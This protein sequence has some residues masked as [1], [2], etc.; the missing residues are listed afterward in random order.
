MTARHPIAKRILLLVLAVT[1]TILIG[2]QARAGEFF[3]KDGAAIR[4][5][6]PV[7]YFKEL[8][9][10]KGSPDYKAEH[11]GSTFYFASEANL[12]MF[13]AEPDRYAP[14]YGGYCAYGTASGYKA[15]TDPA[16]FTIVDGR[17][18]LNY[19]LDVQKQWRVDARGFII[20]ADKKW[21]DVSTQT[22]VFE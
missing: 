9:P 11:K 17:L 21:P 5:Y 7:A 13:Q 16:A 10:V 2:A 6:D 3:E 14:Q 18:Y 4:G 8:G 15:S 22:K 20:E 1:A 19:S 12:M